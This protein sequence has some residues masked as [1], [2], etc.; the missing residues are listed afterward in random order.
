MCLV[1]FDFCRDASTAENLGL[2]VPMKCTQSLLEDFVRQAH[3]TVNTSIFECLCWAE[4]SGGRS[5]RSDGQAEDPTVCIPFVMSME[6]GVFVQASIYRT[7]MAQAAADPSKKAETRDMSTNVPTY[8][9]DSE[10]MKVLFQLR[11][12]LHLLTMPFSGVVLI[13][14]FFPNIY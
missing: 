14:K 11:L 10:D 7:Q 12:N 4:Y 1:Q 5:T 8:D 3:Q 6:I 2:S 13:Q 9:S